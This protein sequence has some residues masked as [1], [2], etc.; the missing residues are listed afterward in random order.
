MNK[1]PHSYRFEFHLRGLITS[2]LRDTFDE[3]TWADSQTQA[4]RF[5]KRRL[6]EKHRL[7]RV[8]LD[9]VRVVT[10]REAAQPAA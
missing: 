2:P 10:K 4:E 7:T 1:I 8:F 3:T 5:I 6:C 9:D